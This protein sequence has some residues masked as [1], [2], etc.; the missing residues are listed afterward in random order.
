MLNSVKASRDVLQ[1]H[2]YQFV[3]PRFLRRVLGEIIGTGLFFEEG[4]AHKKQR[5][6][7]TGMWLFL[8]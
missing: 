3:K 7:L 2:C 8:C 6:L 4:E 1:T 5:R